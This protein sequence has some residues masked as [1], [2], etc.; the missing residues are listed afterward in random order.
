MIYFLKRYNNEKITTYFV[1]R[2]KKMIA[3]SNLDS[4]G[5]ITQEWKV[6]HEVPHLPNDS[7]VEVIETKL[8]SEVQK[9]IKML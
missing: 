2:E 6:T 1:V 5:F 8:P 9:L 7:F 3:I 4:L